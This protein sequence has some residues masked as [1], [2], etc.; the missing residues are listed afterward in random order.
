MIFRPLL[1][2]PLSDEVG[3]DAI[4]ERNGVAYTD[5][6]DSDNSQVTRAVVILPK[7][8]A[9]S[10]ALLEQWAG[11]ALFGRKSSGPG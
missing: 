1:K 4:E 5:I 6:T 8:D 10:I 2:N 9:K 3:G 11:G 7:L